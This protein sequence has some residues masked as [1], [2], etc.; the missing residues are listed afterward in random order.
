[1]EGT[2]GSA[3]GA[4]IGVLEGFIGGTNVGDLRLQP[5]LKKSSLALRAPRPTAVWRPQG[6]SRIRLDLSVNGAR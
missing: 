5:R 1:M 2:E 4:L 3:V 6:P